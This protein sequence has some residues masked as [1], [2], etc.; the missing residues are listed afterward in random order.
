[1]A[2]RARLP[3]LS[4]RRPRPPPVAWSP[5]SPAVASAPQRHDPPLLPPPQWPRPQ[6]RGP[7]LLPPRRPRPRR[8]PPARGP[9]PRRAAPCARPRLP[10]ARRGPSRPPTPL[11]AASRPPAAR[12]PGPL[13]CGPS[14]PCARPSRPR[15]T[16]PALG[17]M[18]PG[19]ARVASTRPRAPPFTPTRSRVR[20]PTRA[21]IYSWFLINFKLRLVSLLSRASSR[22]DSFYLYLLKCCITRFVA[23]RFFLNSVLLT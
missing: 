12:L 19:A 16:A 4:P 6:R 10:V 14:A 15:C 8:R 20:S 7:P 23:R 1:M 9:G 21:V 5:P 13:A 3:R 2:P 17:S 18:D 22:D 11:R